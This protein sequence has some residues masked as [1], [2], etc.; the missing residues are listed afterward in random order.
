MFLNCHNC[1]FVKKKFSR[2]YSLVRVVVTFPQVVLNL[3]RT[4]EN[5]IGS[6]VC[7]ILRYTET[8]RHR[9]FYFYIRIWNKLQTWLYVVVV[10]Y[11]EDILNKKKYYVHV[12]HYFFSLL[13]FLSLSLWHFLFIYPPLYLSIFLIFLNKYFLWE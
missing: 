3:P 10:L 7:E 4:Y 13:F 12:I 11:L 9:S 8:D 5:H 2:S 6:A 1:K